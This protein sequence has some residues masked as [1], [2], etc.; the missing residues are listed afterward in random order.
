MTEIGKEGLTSFMSGGPKTRLTK[1]IVDTIEPQARRTVCWDL[2]V[3]GFCLRVEPTGTKTYFVRYRADGGGRRATQRLFMVGRHGV[4]TCEQA[5]RR[6][7]EVL[8]AVARGEDP[9]ETR[10]EVR[11]DLSVSELLDRYLLEHVDVHNKPTTAREARRH[12]ERNIKPHLGRL[13]LKDLRRSDVKRWHSSFA[14]SPYQGNQ[15]LSYLRKALNLALAEWELID[16]NPASAIKK[17]PEYAR[18]RYF[19]DEELTRI[20]DALVTLEKDPRTHCGAV[21]AVRLLALTGMRLSE[22]LTLK[23]DYVSQSSGAIELPDAKTGARVVPLGRAAIEYLETLPRTCAYVCPSSLNEGPVA[24]KCFRR[25]WRKIV[26]LA[27]LVDARPH[28]FRHTAGTY[29]AQS[30]QNAFMVRDLL[31]HKTLAMTGRY[32]SKSIEPVRAAAD[33]MSSRVSKAMLSGRQ[34][35]TID[36]GSSPPKADIS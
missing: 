32:V 21:I 26:E 3:K 23:W 12:V 22:V 9:A 6:A 31:G 33:Q 11:K 16:V 8:A 29:A 28:D 14:G 13:G 34:R 18:D 1:R 19:S 27:E 36:N 5:R 15:A 17:F 10:I 35:T 30:G 25:L 7:K 4:V 24:V 2:D 20:G